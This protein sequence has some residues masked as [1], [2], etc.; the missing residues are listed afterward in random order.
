[1]EKRLKRKTIN[2]N[3]GH[4]HHFQLESWCLCWRAATSCFD[5]CCWLDRNY[6]LTFQIHPDKNQ[7]MSV[8][9]IRA[10]LSIKDVHDSACSACL[11]LASIKWEFIMGIR[12]SAFS[13]RWSLGRDRPARG[14]S[15]PPTAMTLWPEDLLLRERMANIRQDVLLCFTVKVLTVR[16][17]S[18]GLSSLPW[19]ALTDKDQGTHNDAGQGDAHTNNDPSHRLLVNVVETIRKHWR[20]NNTVERMQI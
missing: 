19:S 6:F 14:T 1:M 13:V 11:T 9:S 7:D 10:L 17:Y 3:N 4:L 20:R 5:S 12:A 8:L 16:H 18:K 15:A 2:Q